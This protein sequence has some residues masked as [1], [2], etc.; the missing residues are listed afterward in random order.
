MAGAHITIKQWTNIDMKFRSTHSAKQRS[1]FRGHMPE[2][3]GFTLWS[4]PLQSHCCVLGPLV[5]DLSPLLSLSSNTVPHLCSG[6]SLLP[7]W[8]LPSLMATW[9]KSEPWTEA[10]ASH[11]WCPNLANPSFVFLLTWIYI[12]LHLSLVYLT[13][14]YSFNLILF[15][16]HFLC[17]YICWLIHG[18]KV[19]KTLMPMLLLLSLR[20]IL[21]AGN[22]ET[23]K[24]CAFCYA[25]LFVLLSSLFSFPSFFH[26]HALPSLL[27]SSFRFSFLVPFP[28]LPLFFEHP[29]APLFLYHLLLLILRLSPQVVP[30]SC[31]SGLCL[32]FHKSYLWEHICLQSLC[33]SIHLAYWDWTIIV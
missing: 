31:P 25:P 10:S 2:C 4:F 14:R 21:L 6:P 23:Q 19:S 3:L 26:S 15:V 17:F 5:L 29:T 27:P 22:L 30:A 32:S 33:A 7:H 11:R 9:S 18:K 13:I 24:K 20:T 12:F 1:M 8:C 28:S 16:S